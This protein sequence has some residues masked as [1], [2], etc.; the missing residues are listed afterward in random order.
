MDPLKF[1]V[2]S[3]NSRQ[4]LLTTD[5]TDITDVKSCLARAAIRVHLCS[6]VVQIFRSAHRAGGKKTLVEVEAIVTV[7]KE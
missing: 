2:H 3:R 5:F 6:S 4:V 7:Q 1:V